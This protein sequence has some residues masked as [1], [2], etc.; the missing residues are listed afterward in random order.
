MGQPFSLKLTRRHAA[1]V[2]L[3]CRLSL[4]PVAI[5]VACSFLA[6]GCARRVDTTGAVAT[7]AAATGCRSHLDCQ[8]PDAGS[9]GAT[10]LY[11]QSGYRC[12][13]LQPEK[14][15]VSCTEDDQCGG[16]NI[17]RPGA[18]SDGGLGHGGL[19][20]T[21]AEACTDDSQCIAGQVCREDP[22]VPIAWIN[23]T[24]LVCSVPCATDLDCSPTTKCASGGHCRVRTCAECPSYLPCASGNCVI[25]SCSTDTDCPGGY[26]VAGN[27]S[28]SLGVCRSPCF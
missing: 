13:P 6:V 11:S 26:C 19:V 20:C 27:C 12:G 8:R 24:G 25:P 16:G 23:P 1:E 3:R 14:V 2:V 5:G 10:C 28:G 4:L 7:D 15:G 17:C 18:V 9:A 22:A 21:R